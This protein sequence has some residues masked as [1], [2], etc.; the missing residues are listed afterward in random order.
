M[1]TLEELIDER[2]ESEHVRRR[3][4]RLTRRWSALGVIY[5]I[6]VW[7]MVFKP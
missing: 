6:A 2:G 7:A 1:K 3:Y 5:L 4:Q